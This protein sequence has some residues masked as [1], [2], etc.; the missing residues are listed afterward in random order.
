MVEDNP[1]DAFLTREILSESG[2]AHYQ[3][4][5]VKDAVEAL[6]FLHRISGFES[7]P[8]PDLILLDLNLPKMHGLDFL[9]EIRKD[10]RFTAVPVV[11]LTTS[12]FKN[13]IDKA[14]EL[15]INGY[16]IK[17]I[18]LEEFESVFL[19]HSSG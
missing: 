17:P 2:N 4:S 1:A 18:D 16:L 7:S 15:G 9:A 13:D 8:L 11:V 12:D 10:K 3:V 19:P 6:S 14:K 5:T